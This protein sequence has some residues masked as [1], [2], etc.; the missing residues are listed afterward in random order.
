MTWSW[1]FD[2]LGTE[3][4]SRAELMAIG[5]TPRM[6]TSAVKH[7]YLVRARRDHYVLPRADDHLVRAV[8]VGG[9]LACDTALRSYGIFGFDHE[10]THVVVSPDASRLRSAHSRRVPLRE[11]D[12]D[13]LE[14]HWSP[15]IR[16]DEATAGRVGVVD[17]LAQVVRCGFWRHAVASLDNAL[18]LGLV[19]EGDLTDVFRG[20]PERLQGIRDR[21]DP[22]CESGQESV[23]RLA[24]E[25]A[26]MRPELQVQV[27]GVGRVDGVI[28]GRLIYEADSRLAHDGWELHVRDRDR[29]I[30][31]ARAGYMSLRPAYRRVMF[32]TADVVDAARG[33]L[34]I[35]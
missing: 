14:V 5:A 16:P 23:L 3:V 1:A 9:R 15:L 35:P 13:R 17:A 31:A 10:R 6:L 28:D 27:E 4:A 30:D 19:D 8:R 29:D 22:R 18:H 7:G 33:L 25:D 11:D 2:R 21:V 12:R 26:G 34:G 24:F 32:A 20:L